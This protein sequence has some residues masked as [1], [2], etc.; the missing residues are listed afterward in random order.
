MKSQI[1]CNEDGI[2]ELG[3]SIEGRIVPCHLSNGNIIDTSEPAAEGTTIQYYTHPTS[4][5]L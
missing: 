2:S 4:T 1:T 5:V 3:I